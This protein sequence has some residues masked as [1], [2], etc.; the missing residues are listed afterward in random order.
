MSKPILLVT[1]RSQRQSE[2]TKTLRRGLF[3]AARNAL[4]QQGDSIRG[5]AL[6]TWDHRGWGTVAASA[7]ERGPISLHLLPTYVQ[8]QMQ[9]Y[10][11]AD[12]RTYGVEVK[13]VNED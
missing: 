6:V 3:K 7:T 8:S 2:Q 11:N 13:D 1:K 5:F 12:D 10:V 4:E 9:R